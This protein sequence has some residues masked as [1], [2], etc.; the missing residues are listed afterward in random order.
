[1]RADSPKCLVF[2]LQCSVWLERTRTLH[3]FPRSVSTTLRTSG[4]YSE[5]TAT[6]GFIFLSYFNFRSF[7]ISLGN[8][9]SNKT[10]KLLFS[11]ARNSISDGVREIFNCFHPKFHL[12][13]SLLSYSLSWVPTYK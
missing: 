8:R 7:S 10:G 1:M 3:D 11:S 12:P 13:K 9:F 2:I 5:K 6:V 4:W